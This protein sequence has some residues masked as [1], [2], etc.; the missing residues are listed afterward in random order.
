MYQT[1][2]AA[3]AGALHVP[4][5]C[6]WQDLGQVLGKKELDAQTK[7]VE[8]LKR[9]QQAAPVEDR[10]A[11]WLLRCHV[12]GCSVDDVLYVDADCDVRMQLRM[13]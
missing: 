1:E 5:S 8:A 3:L 9:E 11:S 12:V 10:E 4:P 7:K 13:W 6:F 2:V